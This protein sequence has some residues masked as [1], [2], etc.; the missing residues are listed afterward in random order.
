MARPVHENRSD[1]MNSPS[2]AALIHES[3]ID[4]AGSERGPAAGLVRCLQAFALR[5][6][7]PIEAVVA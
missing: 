3:L 7:N 1:S 6:S 2:S 4:V 5:M